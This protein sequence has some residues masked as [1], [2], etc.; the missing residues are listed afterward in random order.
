[1][2]MA[3][4]TRPTTRL[5]ELIE[6]PELLVMPCAYDSV[7][8]RLVEEA[9]FPAVQC[10]GL[11]VAASRFG[12]PDLSLVSMQEMVTA[13]RYIAEAVSIPVLG[14][15]DTGFGNTVNA[16]HTVR[17]FERAGA[18]GVNLEDQVLPKRCG[19][20]DGKAVVSI[21]EMV[22]KIEAA[23][24][25]REDDDF[26]IN[27]RT[28]ALTLTGIEDVIERGK[29]YMAAGATM[30]FVEGPRTPGEIERVVAQVDGPIAINII[31]G[32][33]GG[34]DALTFADLEAMG[35]ARVSLSVT[36]LLGAVQGVRRALE[37]L[38]NSGG[39]SHDAEIHATFDDL[40][41]LGGLPHARSLSERFERR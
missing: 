8:A 4:S 32:T 2:S 17:S 10:S 5:R 20:L 19:R 24:D 26:V 21:D 33:E 3:I 30:F 1:M 15:G 29:A 9:G 40:H 41:R 13:T 39:A 23:V 31:E 27:A 12:Y 7:S 38:R 22:G 18:A 14:D 25:A 11:G 37:H 36:S 34:M 28:D 6:A 16:W 35:V